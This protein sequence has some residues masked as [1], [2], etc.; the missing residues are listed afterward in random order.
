[1]R[2]IYYV[3]QGQDINEYRDIWESHTSEIHNSISENIEEYIKDKDV[4][5]WVIIPEFQYAEVPEMVSDED[6]FQNYLYD[7]FSFYEDNPQYKMY[8]YQLN[9]DVK[10]FTPFVQETHNMQWEKVLCKFYTD[11][12]KLPVGWYE[13][14]FVKDDKEIETAQITVYKK[15]DDISDVISKTGQ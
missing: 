15:H 14:R 4:A 1:M 5:Q 6:Y 9:L 10:D 2:K 11:H 13:L 12:I 3:P 8:V 7:D